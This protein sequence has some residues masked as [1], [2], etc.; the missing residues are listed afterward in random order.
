MAVAALL[1]LAV[2]GCTA[3]PEQSAGPSPTG[4]SFS[5]RVLTTGLAD[6]YEITWG[7]DGF[8]WVTEKTGK[9]LTR[10]NPSDGSKSAVATIADVYSTESQD[11]LLGMAFPAFLH[12]NDDV[13]L[14]YTY[15]ADPGQAVDRRAKIVRFTYDP[16]TRH[17]SAGRRSRRPASITCRPVKGS[18]TAGATPCW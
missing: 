2:T 9:R 16:V 4:P 12:G 8:L 5:F 13:Y 7:A 18:S 10:V 14:A 17:T 3:S 15:D 1:A 6:P 11:G